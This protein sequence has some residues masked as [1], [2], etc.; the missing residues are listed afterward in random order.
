MPVRRTAFTLVE[1]LVV[2]AII[3]VLIALL[4]PAVQQAREAARRMQCTNNLKQMALAMHNHHDTYG[5]FPPGQLSVSNYDAAGNSQT[6]HDTNSLSWQV[7]ILPYV[8]QVSLYENLRDE[9]DNFDVHLELFTWWTTGTNFG[10]IVIDGYKCPSC[11]MQDFNPHR[12]DN[13]KTNYKGI[14]GNEYPDNLATDDSG[15]E[16]TFSG[17]FWLNSETSFRDF[18]DGTSNTVFIGEQDGAEKPRRASCWVGS[19]SAHWLNNNLGSTSSRPNFTI[20]GTDRWSALGSMHPGGANFA[21]ADGSVVFIPEVIDGVAYEGL[22][23]VSGGE[24]SPNL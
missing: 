7:F 23:T 12:K 1:L 8:E 5:K 20:N 16:K 22:G 6:W 19:D 13:A 14:L 18:T 9:N 24:L 15:Y 11:P 3:G 2:I 17:S 4:L 21:R 10:R